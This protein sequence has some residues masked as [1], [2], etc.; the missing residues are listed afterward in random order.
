MTGYYR[1]FVQGYAKLARPLTLL[2]QE[3]IPW[4]W[5]PPCQTA[6]D[7]LRCNLMSEPILAMPEPDRP[8]VVHTN[9]SHCALGA[10]LE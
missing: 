3:D 4:V 5:S 1:E 8:F 10:I 2:L 6:F 9:F 7:T